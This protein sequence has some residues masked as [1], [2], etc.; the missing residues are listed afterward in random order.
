MMNKLVC[1]L[2]IDI[3]KNIYMFKNYAITTNYTLVWVKPKAIFVKKAYIKFE[4]DIVQN[5]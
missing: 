2:L 3:L 4:N 1:K 5:Y